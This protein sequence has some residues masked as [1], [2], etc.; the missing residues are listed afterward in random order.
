MALATATEDPRPT[1]RKTAL[2]RLAQHVDLTDTSSREMA[3]HAA[4]ARS[5]RE[6]TDTGVRKAA[7][8]LL[9]CLNEQSG[10]RAKGGD[11]DSG[12]CKSIFRH[13]FLHR[14]RLRSAPNME[15][16]AL[17]PPVRRITNC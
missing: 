12:L 3:S 8:R 11:R 4:A 7:L 15:T 1:I 9:S 5:M 16:S 17:R 10:D 2:E 13:R 14:L 6:E